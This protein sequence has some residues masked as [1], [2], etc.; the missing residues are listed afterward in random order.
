MIGAVQGD[1]AGRSSASP[2][3]RTST[4]SSGARSAP[5][6]IAGTIR[7]PSHIAAE[8][9]PRKLGHGGQ[10]PGDGVRQ[11]RRD[12]RHRRRLHPRSGDRREAAL[13]RIPGQRPGRRRGGRHPHAAGD[14]RGRAR[15][16]AA[17]TS[18]R[19]KTI[20]PET[21][22]EFK[23]H[24]RDAG[25]ALPRNAG[26]RVHHPGRQAL[27]AAMPQ[28]QAHDEGGAEDR[29]RYGARRPDQQGRGRA[30]HRPGAARPAPASDHRP[31]GRRQDHATGLPASPGAAS[32]E[33]VFNADEAEK[34]KAQGKTSSSF[35]PKPA[36]R[37]STACTPPR[38]SSR[39]AAA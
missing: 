35:A 25:T 14:H 21:Y 16:K 23:A 24:L 29:R 31:E 39:R 10:R 27:D 18:R 32:G 38:A 1:G 13:W 9:H 37:T 36:P 3:R 33:I 4:S 2:S 30:A 7:A 20:M 26:R 11:P 15:T 22:A 8:Q 19:W 17:A 34:L 28:R 12:E 5:C 6:S